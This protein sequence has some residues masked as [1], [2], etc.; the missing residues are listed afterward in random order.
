MTNDAGVPGAPRFDVVLRGYDRRQV[1]EHVDRLQRVLV[2]MRG[3]LEIVRSQPVPVVA[4][5]RQPDPNR[6][7]PTPR[8]RPD[9]GPDTIGNFTDRMQSILAEAEAEAAEIRRNAHAAARA[10]AEGVR[11]QVADLIRQRD[12]VLGELTRMRS[13]LEGLL[14]APTTQ[15]Q[16]RTPQVPRPG[17]QGPDQFRGPQPPPPYAPPPPQ[18]GTPPKGPSPQPAPAAAAPP[19][20]S[21]DPARTGSPAP[22]AARPT[23][24]KPAMEKPGTPK[25]PVVSPTPK[26]HAASAPA[27]PARTER[28]AGKAAHRLPSGAY[29]AVAESDSSLRPRT[30]PQIEPADLFRPKSDGRQTEA[31]AAESD[32]PKPAAEQDGSAADRT[33]VVPS[34]RPTG[35]DGAQPPKAGGAEATT[36]VGA[37]RP[38]D[39]SSPSP[40]PGQAT[41]PDGDGSTTG[42][43][44]DTEG[45]M[46]KGTAANGSARSGSPSR[47][48]GS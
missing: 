13:Q 11:S 30:E 15:M 42:G 9:G 36:V 20:P 29:P 48:A 1:D 37:V 43:P 28:V 23:M 21:G 5:N 25:P 8:P 4:P 26:P 39:T 40:S 33:A 12:A 38:R 41:R 18:A 17:P 47:S 2:R 24:A 45:A 19:A 10:E 3:D 34:V 22:T 35:G 14:A 27:A 32:A 44:K 16:A 6:P 7:R 31:R 46:E